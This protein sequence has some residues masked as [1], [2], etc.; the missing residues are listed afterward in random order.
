MVVLE[1]MGV[2]SPLISCMSQR[3]RSCGMKDST[4]TPGLL[5]KHLP[6]RLKFC[7]HFGAGLG[8]VLMEQKMKVEKRSVELYVLWNRNAW[9]CTWI[10]EPFT[11]SHFLFQ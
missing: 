5:K 3:K 8:E 2:Q 4:L 9:G 11:M 7:R 10:L 1:S 6:Q